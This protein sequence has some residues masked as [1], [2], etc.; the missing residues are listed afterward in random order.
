MVAGSIL[1][2]NNVCLWLRIQCL[3][4]WVEKG[5]RSVYYATSI[6]YIPYLD[7]KLQREAEKKN[8]KC[9]KII[10][11]NNKKNRL[12][13]EKKIILHKVLCTLT[14]WNKNN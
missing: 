4:N 8:G 12:Q 2:I 1:I 6:Y 5:E 10:K 7:W 14:L 13:K 3:S 11:S 9:S